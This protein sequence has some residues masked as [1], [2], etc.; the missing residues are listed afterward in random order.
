M[1]QSTPQLV[2]NIISIFLIIKLMTVGH[3]MGKRYLDEVCSAIYPNLKIQ[4]CI[5]DPII[6]WNRLSNTGLVI[7]FW[8]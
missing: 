5:L 7:E 2:D 8:Q 4:V 6:I 3:P 1:T